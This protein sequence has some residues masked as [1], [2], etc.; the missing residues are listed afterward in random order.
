MMRLLTLLLKMVDKEAAGWKQKLN[1]RQGL[2]M[3]RS[4]RTHHLIPSWRALCCSSKDLWGDTLSPFPPTGEKIDAHRHRQHFLSHLSHLSHS[5]ECTAR[6]QSPTQMAQV[7][8]LLAPCRSCASSSDCL[9]APPKTS[10]AFQRAALRSEAQSLGRIAKCHHTEAR[11]RGKLGRLVGWLV[12]F[13]FLFVWGFVC[14][15]SRD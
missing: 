6:P 2:Q 5:L 10:P 12:G 15:G 8:P 9:F 1:V 11:L 13:L 3:Q 4:L 14:R 7:Y